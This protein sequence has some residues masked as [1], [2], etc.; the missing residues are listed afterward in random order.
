MKIDT[1]RVLASVAALLVAG[2]LGGSVLSLQKA[3]AASEELAKARRAISEQAR[4]SQRLQ[5]ELARKPTRSDLHEV[6]QSLAEL[7]DDEETRGEDSESDR[8]GSDAP[9]AAEPE[10]LSQ[11]Q[12][13]TIELAETLVAN[14]AR[15]GRWT[16][17]DRDQLQELLVQVPGPERRRLEDSVGKQLVEGTIIADEGFVPL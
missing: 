13:E 8:E 1:N 7:E 11:Q 15:A 12:T 17:A 16:E 6:A 5:A 3:E 14:A 9:K 10:A 4:V 2:A